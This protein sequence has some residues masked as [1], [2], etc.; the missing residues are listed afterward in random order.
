MTQIRRS[1]SHTD[2][3]RPERK[4]PSMHGQKFNPNPKFLGT[5]E[6]Y[7]VCHIGEIFQIFLIYGCPQSV[8]VTKP[9]IPTCTQRV[10]LPWHST[11]LNVYALAQFENCLSFILLT[12]QFRHYNTLVSS[13]FHKNTKIKVKS[14]RM[15]KFS[16]LPKCSRSAQ[17]KVQDTFYFL[18]HL[19]CIT[20]TGDLISRRHRN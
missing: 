17:K 19:V 7:F 4:Q 14:S 8:L 5:A 3:G 9:Y 12:F 11:Q 1:I 13:C 15:Q 16:G 2:Y 20:L 6:A 10:L 18:Q